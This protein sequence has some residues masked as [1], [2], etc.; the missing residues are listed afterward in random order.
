MSQIEE[1]TERVERLI[2]RYEELRRTNALLAQQLVHVEQER[3]AMRSRLQAARQRIDV[4]LA[5]LPPDDPRG[6]DATEVT[7]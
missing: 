7:S 2:L 3:D 1:L 4:L 5:R 6:P